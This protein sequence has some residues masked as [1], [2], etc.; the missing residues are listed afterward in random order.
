MSESIVTTITTEKG[1][2]S[3]SRSTPIETLDINALD[4]NAL[5]KETVA[6]LDA[7]STAESHSP[8][9]VDFDETL[10]LRNSTEAYL[11]SVYPRPAGAALLFALKALKPWRLLPS[12]MRK[13][14][15][16]KDWC[17]VV[18]ATLLFPWTLLVWQHRAKALSKQYWNE[19]LI[20]A[21][22]ANDKAEIVVATLG[23]GFIVKPLLKYLPLH[24]S[25]HFSRRNVIACR[26]WQGA[27]DRAKGKLEMVREA[28]GEAAL[29][30]AIAVTDSERDKPLLEAVKTP[31]LL[32]WPGAQYV[33]ALAD[34]YMPLFYSEKV[35]N[36]G[37]S[38]FLKRVVMGHWA[39]LA[40]AL[41][42]LSPHP[43]LNAASLFF[44]V[45]SYWCVYEI[46]YQENDVV[47]EKYE[48]KPILS[49]SYERYKAQVDLSTA[50]PWC[51]AAAIAL[52][53]LFFIEVAK[54]EAPFRSAV[55]AVIAEGP[56]LMIYNMA[57]WL[58]FLCAVRLSFWIYN[59]FNEEARIWIYPILQ[60]QKLF[61]F[62]LL[63]GTNAIGAALLLSLI[64]SRWLHYAIYRCGG[65]RWRFPLN[66]CCLVTFL[67][68]YASIAMSG[69]SISDIFTMQAGVALLYCS[70]RSTKAIKTIRTQIR[71]VGTAPSE[72]KA[73]ST[74]EA[75]PASI[76]LTS[77]SSQSPSDYASSEPLHQSSG[78]S[79]PQR[80]QYSDLP[81]R[82]SRRRNHNHAPLRAVR[83]RDPQPTKT[84]SAR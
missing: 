81:K 42:F 27:A 51:W 23:F 43:M 59:Q 44:L 18:A 60:V 70:L 56:T 36:P 11:D 22:R 34:V 9:V 4:I 73:V 46:G 31:C 69:A 61:G 54:L 58:W 38:H 79:I 8:I 48:K 15:V 49:S 17:F 74:K 35:K 71:L 68:M 52:P 67:M 6:V 20:A 75:S 82:A 50:A 13:D 25:T 57:V 47:G 37:K 55:D 30:N 78:S 76:R 26:F 16:A 5:D 12:Y 41:S 19:P 14:E 29:S 66:L 21:M 83:S 45:V 72:A 39:F 40:I 7:V 64:V 24:L 84:R 3:H 77:H 33:P 10:F 65:D 53:A 63:V 1:I 80:R 2:A 32:V 62:T 28:L